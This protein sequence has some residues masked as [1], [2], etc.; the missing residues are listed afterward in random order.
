MDEHNSRA[1]NNTSGII[2]KYYMSY[3]IDIPRHESA[4]LSVLPTYVEIRV[5]TSTRRRTLSQTRTMDCYTKGNLLSVRSC[6]VLDSEKL[7]VIYQGKA[8]VFVNSFLFFLLAIL[9]L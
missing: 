7:L 2:K 5:I 8:K 4:R 6:S 3:K 1:N 9:V